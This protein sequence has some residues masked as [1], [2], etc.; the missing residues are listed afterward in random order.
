MKK[1]LFVLVCIAGIFAVSCKEKQDLNDDSGFKTDTVGHFGF[2]FSAGKMD[3]TSNWDLNMNDGGVIGWHSGVGE[4]P[5]YPS[6]SN[7]IWY[8]NS[9]L[10]LENY[11]SQIKNYGSVNIN[12]IHSISTDWDTIID[13]LNPGYVFGAKCK[14]GYVIFEVVEVVDTLMWRALLKYK[15]S[16]DNQF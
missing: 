6:Y 13:P 16:A 4:N 5:S 14:D 12:S 8:R 1:V 2:D 3:T 9:E 11:R 10:D 7:Y 15:F